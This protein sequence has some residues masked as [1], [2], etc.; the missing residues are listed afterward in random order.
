MKKNK[1]V[2]AIKK[3]SK[4]VKKTVKKIVK[5]TATKIVKKTDSLNFRNEI[6]VLDRIQSDL[7][8]AIAAKPAVMDV[9]EIRLYIDN[10]FLVLNNTVLKIKELKNHL[11]RKETEKPP[12]V[13]TYN[14]P[15]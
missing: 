12:V 10:V 1:K 3:I 13:E 7:F 2:K 5:K 4:P 9:E 14:P 15:A 8:E 11:Q 6:K